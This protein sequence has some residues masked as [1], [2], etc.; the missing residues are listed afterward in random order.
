MGAGGG[1]GWGTGPKVVF[2]SLRRTLTPRPSLDLTSTLEPRDPTFEFFF[3][4]TGF[5]LLG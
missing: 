2:L 1:V 5:R 4:L 3:C